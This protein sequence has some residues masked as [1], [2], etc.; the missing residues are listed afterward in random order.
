MIELLASIFRWLLRQGLT[1]ALIL[2]ILVGFAWVRGE[3][4]RADQLA[5]E[6]AGLATR[7]EALSGE[8]A[9]LKQG[10][11]QRFKKSQFFESSLARK[12]A[13]RQKLWDG[14]FWTRNVPGS[15]AWTEIK[16][17]DAEIAGYERIVGSVAQAN[18]AGG[19]KLGTL[20]LA[21]LEVD[22]QITELD[23]TLAT[24]FVSRVATIVDR[25]LPIAV[26]IL[27]GILLVPLGIKA[28]LY[29]VVAPWATSRPP[30]RLLPSAAGRV[31]AQK[32]AGDRV[33]AVSIPVVL[34]DNQ[35]L[36][37]QPDYLQSTSVQAKKNTKWLLNWS[38]PL[39]SL[40]SGMFLLTRVSP[41][42]VEPVVLSSSKDPLSELGLIDLAEG[43]AFV[44]RPRALAGV[45]QDR[46]RPTRITRHWRLGLQA[47]LTLQLRFLAFH[48]P[49]QLV[50]KGCR[51]ICAERAGG[52]RM[53]NQA[54]TLGF[55][56]DISYGNTRCETFISYWRGKE[57]LFND[58]FS[59]ES[60]IYVYEETPSAGRAA[61][62]GRPIEGFTDALLKAFGV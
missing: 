16:V 2:I 27:I 48:G 28:L 53:I 17:L 52:G 32:I 56:A 22:R 23:T 14:N 58:V 6:R 4:K 20:E 57:E 21:K 62:I 31:A 36:L 5:K 15:D 37:I 45:I 42:G 33:S 35:E 3:L 7:Q 43:A 41:A 19:R 10:A 59:G 30:T 55:S 9:D 61:G 38:I 11:L 60:G 26:A 46:A 34:Q 54:A 51:G 29:F 18:E 50:V 13:E 12:Q 47:W 24:S 44:V 25:E 39:S 8:I 49:A 1:L 40:L